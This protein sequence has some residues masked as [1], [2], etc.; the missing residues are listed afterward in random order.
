MNGG[1]SFSVKLTARQI[2]VVALGFA[3]TMPLMGG[4]RS[5][6]GAPIGVFDSVLGGLI[7]LGRLLD[8]DQVNNAT[9][10]SG[11]DGVPD[12]AHKSFTHLGD[13]ANM[14]YGARRAW[15]CRSA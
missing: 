4:A 15:T 7:V 2:A 5:D 14:P 9:G 3:A 10:P 12:L 1:Y 13:Q 8:V 6:S 11:P